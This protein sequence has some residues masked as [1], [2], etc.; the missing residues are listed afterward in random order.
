MTK[1]DRPLKASEVAAQQHRPF[2]T[3]TNNFS[4]AFPTIAETRI[5]IVSRFSPSGEKREY[6]TRSE[7]REFID[8]TNRRCYNGGVRLGQ[9]L[10]AMVETG[11]TEEE[12]NLPCQ[13]YEGSPK[14]RRKSG[15]CDNFF[16]IH[17]VL[18]LKKADS[19]GTLTGG[20]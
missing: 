11:K 1:R 12:L 7:P 18:T 19:G 13:G 8:C 5:D 6:S 4:Q 2:V 16:T 9:L 15:P 3:T 10:R 17:I 14:G 20:S